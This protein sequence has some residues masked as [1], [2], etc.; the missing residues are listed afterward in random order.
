MDHAS[1]AQPGHLVGGVHFVVVEATRRF[2]DKV[3]SLS[4]KGLW[5]NAR[6]TWLQK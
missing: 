5:V 4:L 3:F 6:L 1:F 2:L